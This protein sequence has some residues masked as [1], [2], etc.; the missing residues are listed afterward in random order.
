LKNSHNISQN[1]LSVDNRT[2]VQRPSI[3]V[4]DLKTNLRVRRFE[5]PVSS[6]AL[7]QGLASITV[8]VEAGSCNNAFAYLPDLAANRLH[9]YR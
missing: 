1:T 7:G 4:I 3:W 6:G 8:D 9:V 2:E 5:I